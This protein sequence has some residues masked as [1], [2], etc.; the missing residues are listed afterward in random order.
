MHTTVTVL[1][2]AQTPQRGVPHSPVNL[3]LVRVE[4]TWACRTWRFRA[5]EQGSPSYH[6]CF[7]QDLPTLWCTGACPTCSPSGAKSALALRLN[8]WKMGWLGSAR[9]TV[10][11]N[12]F[13]E[14]FVRL[15][16]VNP[17]TRPRPHEGCVGGCFYAAPHLKD[18]KKQKEQ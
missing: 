6:L 1:T 17:L 7:I 13:P 2:V 14:L 9:N 11:R 8:Q 12:D 10:L 18:R 15:F 5:L 4:S 16:Y 3:S